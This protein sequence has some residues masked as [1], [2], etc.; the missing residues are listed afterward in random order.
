MLNS[1]FMVTSSELQGLQTPPEHL[2]FQS[3]DLLE[4]LRGACVVCN[5]QSA[6]Q[7]QI[8]GLAP[9]PNVAVVAVE[10]SDS[11]FQ[12]LLRHS[13]EH[14]WEHEAFLP[15]KAREFIKFMNYDMIIYDL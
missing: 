15:L 11:N 1:C 4:S 12:L 6:S 5:G 10:P 14:G 7:K 8:P 3:S 13:K 2:R 9:T